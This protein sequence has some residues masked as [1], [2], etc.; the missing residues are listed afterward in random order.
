[1][2]LHRRDDFLAEGWPREMKAEAERLRSQASQGLSEMAR[3]LFGRDTRE[4]RQATAFAT[5]DIPYGAVRR[6]I[7]GGTKPPQALDALIARAYYG[8]IDDAK[9]G[10]RRR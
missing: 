6:C 5:V 1:M 3:R 9:A 4:T 8:V 10:G 2:V 7:S